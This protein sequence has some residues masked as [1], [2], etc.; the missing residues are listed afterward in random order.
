MPCQKSAYRERRRCCL[1]DLANALETGK[2]VLT[3]DLPLSDRIAWELEA[4]EVK[5]T[6]AGNTVLDATARELF[7]SNNAP[8]P[9]EVGRVVRM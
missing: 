2:I 4:F 5:T 8:R 7:A 3:H 6:A 1:G 9:V